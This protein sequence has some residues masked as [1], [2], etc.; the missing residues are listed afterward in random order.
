M[1]GRTA[2]SST[3][4]GRGVLLV[5]AGVWLL[6]DV[7]RVWTPS[8][9]TIFGRAA[10]TP[11]EYI[12]L[13]ALAIGAT[14]LLLTFVLPGTDATET[15][16]LVGLAASRLALAAIPGGRPQLVVA[17]AGA[18]CGIYWLA[19][20]TGRHAAVL[21]PGLTTGL[22]LATTAHAALGTYNA[23]WR[24]DPWAVTVL[25]VHIGLLGYAAGG[26][27]G[28]LGT[29]GA[30]GS[31][32]AAPVG[33]RPGGADVRGAGGSGRAAPVGGRPGG[34]DA[35]GHDAGRGADGR[36]AGPV[37]TGPGRLAAWLVF[38]V[39]LLDGVLFLDAGR[40]SALVGPA[41]PTLAV[42]GA[43]LAVARLPA[44]HPLLG[45]AGAVTVGG[46]A[47]GLLVPLGA[48]WPRAVVAL[49]FVLGPAAVAHLLASTVDRQAT[50]PATRSVAAGAIAWVVL[51][52]VY[53]AGYDLGYRA[54]A[55]LVALAVAVAAA[56]WVG[57][58]GAGGVPGAAGSR[59][60][61]VAAG[62]VAVSL[63]AVGPVLTLRP[64]TA[65]AAGSTVHVVAYNLRMGYGLDGRFDA[66]AVAELLV[67]QRADVVLLS[68]IDRGWLLNGGQDQLRILGRLTGMH[69]AF[70]A[71][72][73][74]VW[75]DAIL[76]RVPLREVTSARLRPYGSL[77]GGEILHARIEWAGRS[78]TVVSTH[79]QPGSGP[80]AT[81]RQAAD[82]AADLRELAAAGPVIAG[83]DLNT[84][85]GGP[86]WAQLTAAGLTDALAPARPLLTSAADDLTSQIDHIFVSPT[87]RTT[88]ART[89]PVTLSDHL[90]VLVD[91]TL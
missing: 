38:P 14:P 3:V 22:L 90:P 23:V 63:A 48:T 83:G 50:G 4:V 72:A 44:G 25:V 82:L 33:G 8:L 52:F 76:S 7:L 66:R 61:V 45:A 49:P 79:L 21:V 9:I 34:A 20:A 87:I 5:A 91:L 2:G 70:G 47:L 55:L 10:E 53:Y 37:G 46:C 67:G 24:H 60:R 41:G 62:V 78:V 77:T 36:H 89:V 74:P 68:E 31:G 35:D 32:R 69:T 42:L 58:T 12:G 85:P 11:A 75:G 51:L 57:R 6:V 15:A 18:A 17:S 28:D 88:N 26:R 81:E 84:Q 64:L 59:G 40:A 19:L 29:R 27:R 30:G 56:P 13:Y 65:P 86:A 43:A 71:A 73:D 16:A 54:D 80:A 39:L 1:T